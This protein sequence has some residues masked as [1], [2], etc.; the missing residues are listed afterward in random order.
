MNILTKIESLQD[1]A[2]VAITRVIGESSKEK[3][4]E[5]LGFEYLISRKRLRKLCLFYTTVAN[6]SRKLSL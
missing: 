5:E 1:N 4:Y 6:K 2:T 3:L